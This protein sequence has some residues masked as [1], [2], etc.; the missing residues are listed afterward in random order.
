MI[1]LDHHAAR[2]GLRVG[3]TLARMHRLAVFDCPLAVPTFE[4][5]QHWHARYHEDAANRWL[6]GVV[7]ALFMRGDGPRR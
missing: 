7:A 1:L 5:K 6:R 3:E 2:Q 4:V